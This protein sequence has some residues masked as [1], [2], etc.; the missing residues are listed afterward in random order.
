MGE[1]E[2]S[3]VL[4]EAMMRLTKL[5]EDPWWKIDVVGY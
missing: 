1:S 4:A 2:L 3:S 5:I